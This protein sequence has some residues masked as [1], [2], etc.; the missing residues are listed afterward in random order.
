MKRRLA[1]IRGKNP[2]CRSKKEIRRIAEYKEISIKSLAQPLR[3]SFRRS[4]IMKNDF[5]H[6]DGYLL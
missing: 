4:I 5:S 2:R 3:P 1:I 6:P